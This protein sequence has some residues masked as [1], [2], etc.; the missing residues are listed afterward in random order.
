MSFC[1]CRKYDQVLVMTA[2]YFVNH[3][4]YRM[5]ATWA[6]N[7]TN[8][9]YKLKS[10]RLVGVTDLGYDLMGQLFS[11]GPMSCKNSRAVGKHEL[12]HNLGAVWSDF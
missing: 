6:A 8:C 11:T 12:S 2:V 10:I 9:F 3:I 7:M 5:S 1:L 4:V